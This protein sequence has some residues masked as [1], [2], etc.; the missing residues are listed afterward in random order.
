M[1]GMYMQRMNSKKDIWLLQM[2]QF[3]LNGI[4]KED[5]TCVLVSY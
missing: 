3:V 2:T 1:T 5:L 4:Y